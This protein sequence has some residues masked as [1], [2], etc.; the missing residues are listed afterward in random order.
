MFSQTIPELVLSSIFRQNLTMFAI[1]GRMVIRQ[2]LAFFLCIWKAMVSKI[3]RDWYPEESSRQT[4]PSKWSHPTHWVATLVCRLAIWARQVVIPL[5][6]CLGQ[7]I[8]PREPARWQEHTWVSPTACNTGGQRGLLPE[9]RSKS[10]VC[11]SMNLY[12]DR[13]YTVYFQREEFP[14]GISDMH[15]VC[16][17]RQVPKANCILDRTGYKPKHCGLISLTGCGRKDVVCMCKRMWLVYS[18]WCGLYIN[19]IRSC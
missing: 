8:S 10:G 13:L 19:F 7:K 17:S 6:P 15:L 5:L 3:A 18:V 1:K 11:I 4:Y 2:T 12:R 14:P 9:T 16:L